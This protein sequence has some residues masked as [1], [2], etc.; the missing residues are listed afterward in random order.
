MPQPLIEDN[1]MVLFQG[2]SITD[3]GR[4]YKDSENMGTGY[5][6]MASAFF[7]ARHPEKNVH[8]INRGISGNRVRDLRQRWKKDCLA[9][10]PTWVSIM[11][12]INDTWRAFDS[13]D[14]TSIEAYKT[15]L[16][17][18]LDQTK[19]SL[20]ARMIL[21]EPFLLPLVEDYSLWR[22]D[23]DP[24]IELTHQLAKQYQAILI[25]TDQLFAKVTNQQPKEFWTA[26][27]VHPTPA[28]HAIIA[29]AWLDAVKA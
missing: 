24:R 11:I 10:K 1:A 25:P 22:Q 26:D 16:T 13:N 12:G 17:Y 27:G 28:G 14:P 3:A 19:E 6:M 20:N 15:N 4:Q 9:I 29:Q 21:F 8:F 23:L 5:A 18:I 2:D 7:S